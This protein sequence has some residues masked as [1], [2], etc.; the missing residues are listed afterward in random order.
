MTMLRDH[1]HDNIFNSG[2]PAKQI[3]DEIG[4]SYSYLA[5]A[6]NPNLEEFHFQ[7]KHL[8]PLTKATGCF[9]ARD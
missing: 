4:I 7:L 3:A 2:R 1:L 9:D 8:I 6:G 5:S